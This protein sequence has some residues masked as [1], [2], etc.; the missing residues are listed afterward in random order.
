MRGRNGQCLLDGDP[1]MS[2]DT[3]RKGHG[4][5]G[6]STWSAYRFRNIVVKA[7]DGKVLLEG[8][9][10]LDHPADRSNAAATTPN[11]AVSSASSTA[12]DAPKPAIAPFTAEQAKKYQEAW[13]QYLKVP[14]EHTNS[15]GMKFILI[16]PGEFTMGSTQAEIEEALKFTDD[17][18][19]WQECIK[20][21]AP[22]H[23]V[24]LTQPFYL[25]A[26]EVTQAEYEQVMGENPSAFAPMGARKDAIAEMDTTTH[27]VEVVSW[28]DAAEFCAKLSEKEKLKP[29]YFRSGE[30][31]TMLAA[32]TGYHLPT[33]AQWE[34]A[35][36]AGT[37]T[38]YWV[39]DQDEDLLQADWFGTNSGGRTHQVGELKANPLGLYDIHGNVWEWVQDGWEPAY[40]RQFQDHPALNPSG[41]SS[42]GSQRVVRGGDFA[43]P[44][45]RASARGGM[46]PSYRGSGGFRVSLPIDA[47]K[48]VLAKQPDNVN[49]GSPIGALRPAIAP[50][51]SKQALAHQEAWAKHLGAKVE[52]E[53]SLGMKLR[54]IPPG[55]FT[56]GSPQAEIDALVQSTTDRGWQGYFRGEGPQH[57]VRLTQ[58]FYLGSCEVTQQKY[59]EL[60]G[61]NPSHFSL[62]GSGKDAVKDL[63]TGQHPVDQVSWFDAIDFCNKLSEREQRSPY[64]VRD[65]EGVKIL[66]GTGYRLPTEAEW[67]YACRAGTTTRWSFGD[68]E[69]KLSQHAWIPDNAGD[70][71]HRVGELRAN[72]FGLYDL[73]GNLWEWCSDWEGDYA[74]RAD[75][76]PPGPTAGSARVFRGGAYIHD[77]TNCRSAGRSADVPLNRDPN[78]GFRVA[79]TIDTS[80]GRDAAR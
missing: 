62:T 60:M 54:L 25:G 66:G 51:D 29:C 77:M 20:S 48:S 12:T 15:V 6:L 35:C 38:K 55:E 11:S 45:G 2:F 16:P 13:A 19:D 64:Y 21:E 59:Q 44:G 73:H 68:N 14:V 80:G 37:T 57:V 4:R 28:N 24:I 69:T 74:A 40:Y 5:V 27:P 75:S 42:A 67:E 65:G 36:R 3:E 49:A 26:H 63:D 18:K 56:M 31:V 72:S 53:N 76:D 50:F 70:R 61:V 30:T 78:L 33:E 47:V 32:G 79:R 46:D 71:T 1:I 8:L 23:K 22:Q 41:P 34:F 52:I 10:D 39:G 9:P 7:P 58:A 43:D 17:N